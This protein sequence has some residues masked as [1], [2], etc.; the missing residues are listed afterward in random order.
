[1]AQ[2]VME[3]DLPES[4]PGLVERVLDTSIAEKIKSCIQC[5][6]C[7]AS[8]PTAYAMDYTPRQIIAAL[9]AGQW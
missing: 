4:S 8:C 9:R 2:K 3:A 7:S 1:M 6:A 5:G